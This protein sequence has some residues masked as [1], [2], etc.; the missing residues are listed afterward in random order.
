MEAMEIKSRQTIET[1]IQLGRMSEEEF[2][3]AIKGYGCIYRFANKLPMTE[4]QK[5]VLKEKNKDK[6]AK[7]ASCSQMLPDFPHCCPCCP[8]FQKN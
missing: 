4:D 2:A 7:K 3:D 6:K 1:M 5:E 8:N